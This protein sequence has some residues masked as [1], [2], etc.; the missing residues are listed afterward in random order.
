M[1][2]LKAL[3][4]EQGLTQRDIANLT[5]MSIKS[6]QLYEAGKRKPS[7]KNL[8]ALA[9]VLGTTMDQLF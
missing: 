9:E 8:K 5:G 6:Y 4:D 2:K 1:T 3:R 7:Y